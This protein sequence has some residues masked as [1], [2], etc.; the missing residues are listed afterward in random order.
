MVFATSQGDA[1]QKFSGE[2]ASRQV[3]WTGLESL[4]F[5]EFVWGSGIECSFLPHINV[6]QY[7]W[8]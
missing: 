2:T 1:N 5:H 8:T 6:D 3:A 7:H 4:P